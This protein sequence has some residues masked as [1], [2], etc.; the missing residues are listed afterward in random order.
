MDKA[1]WTSLAA[2]DYQIPAER[3]LKNLTEIL[4]SYLSSPDP[5]LRDEIG[6]I[7]YANWL[8]RE[9]YSSDTVKSHV[10]TLLA[11]LDKGIGETESDT[12]FLR[13]FSILLLAEI[14]HNDN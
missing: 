7:A 3:T 5:E 11:N 10:E 14:I 13:A 6:Y 1:F 8:K 9:M 2:N 4:F 12:L